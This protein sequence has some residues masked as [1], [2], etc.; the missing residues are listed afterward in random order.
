M[1]AKSWTK[2]CSDSA[3]PVVGDHDGQVL[4]FVVHRIV[5]L[6]VAASVRTLVVAWVG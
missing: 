6:R 1:N 3:L 2:I 4:I 5:R